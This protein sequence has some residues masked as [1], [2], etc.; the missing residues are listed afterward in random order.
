MAFKCVV[1]T[2]QENRIMT[3]YRVLNTRF[4]S[5]FLIQEAQSY[6][7]LAPKRVRT[8]TSDPFKVRLAGYSRG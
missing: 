3:I 8:R 7:L 4:V 1:A 5:H 2:A 6:A